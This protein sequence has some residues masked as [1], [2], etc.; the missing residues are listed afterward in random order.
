[1]AP[2]DSVFI[3]AYKL[4]EKVFKSME[5]RKSKPQRKSHKTQE[6]ADCKKHLDDAIEQL[7][8][9]NETLLNIQ[10]LLDKHPHYSAYNEYCSNFRGSTMGLLEK[11]HQDLK[12]D[13]MSLTRENLNSYTSFFHHMLVICTWFGYRVFKVIFVFRSTTHHV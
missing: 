2:H 11:F 6:G 5:N 7:K 8:K 12:G 10:A 3:G 1:M 9:L 4:T 13:N